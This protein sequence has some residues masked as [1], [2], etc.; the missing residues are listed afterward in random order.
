M[1]IIIII[2]IIIIVQQDTGSECLCQYAYL[3]GSLKD[4]FIVRAR[5]I[6]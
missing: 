5:L 4:S 1:T 2:I 6:S 3:N